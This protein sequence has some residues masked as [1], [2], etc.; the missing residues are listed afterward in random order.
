MKILGLDLGIGS[1]GWAL[2]E[3]DDN[4]TPLQILGMGSRIVRLSPDESSGFDKG[5]GES[6][7]SQRTAMRTARKG[8]DRYQMRRE[9]LHNRLQ[10]HGMI[11][12]KNDL[13]KLPPLELW[14]LRAEGV[15]SKLSLYELGRVLM[16]INQKRG[17]KHAKSD[18]GDSRQTEYVEKVNANFREIKEK[19]QTVGQSFYEKLQ[20]SVA[21]SHNGKR[22]VSYR[23]KDN[24]FPR[25]AYVDEVT[26][27]LQKQSEYYPDI[28]TDHE[29]EEITN[30]IFYQRPLKSCKHLVGI[31]EFE[32]ATYKTSNGREV[33][34][35]P[36][37]APR[38]SP[39][40]QVCRIWE[41]VNNIRLTN[42]FNRGKKG[43]VQPSLFDSPDAS[44]PKDARLLMHDYPFSNE[45]RHRIFDYLNT[46]EK[47]SE[48]EL[49]K[50]LGLKKSDGFKSDRSL[51]KGIQGNI[52][53]SDIRKALGDSSEYDHL[54]QFNLRYTD[55]VDNETGEIVSIVSPDYISQPLYE[56]WHTLYSISDKEE[57]FNALRN[58][59]SIT[60]AEVLENLY[61]LDFVKAGY[62]NKSAKFMRR[63]IP[64]MKEGMMYS[65]ACAKAG[66]NHSGSIT[67]EENE[68]RELKDH[69]DSLGKN[70]LRQPVVEKILNQ[71]INVV[72]ELIKEYGEI[73]E[74]RIELARQLRQSKDQRADTFSRINKREKENQKIAEK[75]QEFNIQPSRNRIQKYRLWEETGHICIYCGQTVQATE[76]L[77]G[78]GAEIE[79]IIPRSIFFDDSH[80]N[81][82]CACRK[83]NRDKGNSTGYDFMSAKSEDEFTK[84]LKRV[85]DLYAGKA[86]SKTK[87]D[88]LLTPGDKIPEDF[89]NRDLVLS[90]Y[91]ARKASEILRQAA[92]NVW[93]TSGSVTD[94]LRHSWGYDE[95]LHN[96]NIERYSLADNVEEV[97]YT[98]SGQEHKEIRIKDW[99]KRLD[100]RHHALDALTIALTQQN[101]IQRLNNLNKER[102]NLHDDILNA[103]G[104]FKEGKQLLRQWAASRPHFSV[105]EVARQL[106]NIAVS[107]KSG[108]KLATPGK[109]YV[110]KGG[111]RIVAQDGL[112]IPRGSLHQESI[113]GKIRIPG[114]EEK[115]S[116]AFEMPERIVNPKIRRLVTDRLAEEG[117]DIK[118]AVKSLKKRPIT[119]MRNGESVVIEKVRV[120]EDQFVIKYPIDSIKFKDLDSIVDGHIRKA[121]EK[122]FNEVGNDDKK[123]V[124]SLENDPIIPEGMTASVRSVRC[125]TGLKEDKLVCVR[126]DENGESIGYAKTGSNHHVAIYQIGDGKYFTSVVTFWTALKRKRLGLPVIISDPGLAWDAAANLPE[127]DDLTEVIQTL[128]PH[129][130]ELLIDMKMG[131]MFILGMSEDEYNDAVEAGNTAALCRHL[132]R[133]QKLTMNCYYFRYH[134]ETT[135]GKDENSDILMDS[136]K[137]ISSIN[138][139]KALNPHKIN[140]TPTGKLIL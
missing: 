58:K 21:K 112:L 104:E 96:V 94:F 135:I 44:I 111:K 11:D 86:I 28:L 69:L 65:E 128:P 109:R 8:Q 4:K 19:Q 29:I 68:S 64:F 75:I 136:L 63:I 108:K 54:L 41:A 119:I 42:V 101:V 106:N 53:Y 18:V 117:N 32:K 24:V 105:E 20:H 82:V 3:T 56:L 66:A 72:N 5:S 97:S 34:A 84:Y 14:K 71:M 91:I 31:C 120:F 131:D 17:Y 51:G 85:E 107:F 59:F 126:R 48:T 78:N 89:L 100:H 26:A 13:N 134:T 124:K 70:E 110:R 79:H 55:A 87:R 88:R 27:I 132:Y 62:S 40:A 39:I 67:K 7:C 113:Y 73:D 76:F 36:R 114:K 139:L 12:C 10:T 103:G 99:S 137:R 1:I 52:T 57:L 37:V 83:C 45:E 15:T 81:K 2:I 16:H 49:L 35:G 122:R 98:H 46:H 130:S 80:S 23:I 118:A 116:K 123:F 77:E 115:L 138:A 129:N 61:K 92:R 102:V 6:V 30:I 43:L 25:Q 95:I 121:L 38:T 47:L 74:I 9:Q 60:D 133:V 127:S 140:V 93:A 33:T 90:Q 50:I 125:L 22:S